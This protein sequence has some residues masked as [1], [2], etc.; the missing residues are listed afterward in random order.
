MFKEKWNRLCLVVLREGPGRACCDQKH[1]SAQQRT[2]ASG[3]PGR[4]SAWA[5]PPPG[6]ASCQC[7]LTR[8]FLLLT[9]GSASDWSVF[10]VCWLLD[11]W[12]SPLPHLQITVCSVACIAGQFFPSEPSAK[13]LYCLNCFKY[14]HGVV[15]LVTMDTPSLPVFQFVKH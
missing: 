7:T 8:P 9:A 1:G 12:T 2:L 3:G 11:F 15:D 5:G 10:T 14:S 13:P 4:A 6:P